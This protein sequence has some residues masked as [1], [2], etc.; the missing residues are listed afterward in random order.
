MAVHIFSLAFALLGIIGSTNT[1]NITYIRIGTTIL[2]ILVLVI[3]YIVAG[4]KKYFNNFNLI[5][6]YVDYILILAMS[7]NIYMYALLFPILFITIMYMKPMVTY[8]TA[9]TYDQ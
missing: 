4:K 5:L 9:D 8:I 7:S 3:G 6:L 1:K 2:L